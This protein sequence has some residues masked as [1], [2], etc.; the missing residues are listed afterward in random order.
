MQRQTNILYHVN[1]LKEWKE[2]CND[3]PKTALMVKQV[4]LEEDEDD[5][6]A[7]EQQLNADIEYLSKQDQTQLSQCLA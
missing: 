1:L 7:Q 4:N 3:A 5:K 2:R 6:L